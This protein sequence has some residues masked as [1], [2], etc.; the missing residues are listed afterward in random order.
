MKVK[1]LEHI[2]L[3]TKNI[4]TLAIWYEN[5]LG[6]KK[7]YRPPFGVEGIWLYADEIPMIHLLSIPKDLKCESPRM[8]HF[9][10]RAEGLGD[11]LTTLKK[12]GISYATQRVPELRI[13]QVYISDPDGNN[14]H[15][16]FSPEEAEKLGY[17]GD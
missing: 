7:G 15:I 8:E 5:I 2:N 6:L 3:K 4:E 9:C 1:L 17:D 10:M 16:D 14:M 11:F 13:L 12:E